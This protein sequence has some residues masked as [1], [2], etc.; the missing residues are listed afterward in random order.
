MLVF[1]VAALF[2]WDALTTTLILGLGGHELNPVMVLIVQNPYVLIAF[3]FLFAVLVAF[4][5]MHAD[6]KV[7]A[8][9]S[10]FL[11]SVM[12]MYGFVI[13]NNVTVL[14]GLIPW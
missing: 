6:R 10:A 14:Q 9:G 13:W 5:A 3:K 1:A 7:P 2:F 12:L 8:S 4:I 11:C